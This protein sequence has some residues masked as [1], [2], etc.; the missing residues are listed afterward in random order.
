MI[1]GHT[2]NIGVT[3][4][5]SHP[6]TCHTKN[7]RERSRHED[8]FSAPYQID[9]GGAIGL[10]CELVVSLVDHHRRFAADFSAKAAQLVTLNGHAGRIVG[11][12][13]INEAHRVIYR[14]RH[15]LKVNCHVLTQR[16]SKHFNAQLFGI[17][18][19]VGISECGSDHLA[20]FAKSHHR[21]LQTFVGS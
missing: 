10:I 6:Q 15:R 11:V 5:V 16:H 3:H 9:H 8:I 12:A 14:P 17:V 21:C 2:H 20:A 13:E 19:V 18:K 7:F 1:F 4:A